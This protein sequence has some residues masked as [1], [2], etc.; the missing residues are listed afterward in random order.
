M[1]TT[2]GGESAATTVRIMWGALLA[3]VGLFAVL[4]FVLPPPEAPQNPVLATALTGMGVVEFAM[5]FLVPSNMEKRAVANLRLEVIEE[6]DP[7]A[8]VL[9]RDQVPKRRVFADPAAVRETAMRTLVTTTILRC[10]LS[11]GS[12]V[13]G[14]V[15]RMTGGEI[16]T[17]LPLF[18]LAAVALA[19]HFP[20]DAKG[21]AP[22]ERHFEAKLVARDPFTRAA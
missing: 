15:L 10:A 2:T 13:L 22:F 4:V 12:A 11:V 21:I 9:F 16:L 14:L 20:S 1:S 18:A 3:A 19:A 7:N 17:V 5:S 6:A 8:E